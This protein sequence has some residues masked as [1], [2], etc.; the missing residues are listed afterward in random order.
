[1][2]TCNCFSIGQVTDEQVVIDIKAGCTAQLVSLSADDF[3]LRQPDLVSPNSLPESDALVEHHGS[4]PDFHTARGNVLVV[5]V[6]DFTDINF[7]WMY[8]HHYFCFL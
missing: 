1:M 2:L 5:S 3:L 8:N 6:F 7:C 4:Q